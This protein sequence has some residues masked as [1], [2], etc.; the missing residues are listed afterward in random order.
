MPVSTIRIIA[1]GTELARRLPGHNP[2]SMQL[3][4]AGVVIVA[5]DTAIAVGAFAQI[6]VLA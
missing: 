6:M 2:Q 1:I 4:L 5:V 3:V